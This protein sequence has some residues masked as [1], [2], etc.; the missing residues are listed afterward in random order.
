MKI[1]MNQVRFPLS[2][3]VYGAIL[4]EMHFRCVNGDVTFQIRNI[5]YR[6]WETKR[7]T[8]I[9]FLLTM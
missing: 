1:P 5:K 3:G 4:L 6:C 2:Q 8:K 7:L 9:L